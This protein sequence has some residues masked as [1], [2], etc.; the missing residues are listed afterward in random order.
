MDVHK[1][2]TATDPTVIITEFAA[3][4]KNFVVSIPLIKF[5]IPIKDFAF[6]SSNG[7]RVMYAFAFIELIATR[8][9]G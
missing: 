6:G 1:M 8:K 3:T 4:E 9:I 7:F 5:V 2:I